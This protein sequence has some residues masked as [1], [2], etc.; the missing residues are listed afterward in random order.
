MT[1]DSKKHLKCSASA[2]GVGVPSGNPWSYNSI[3]FFVFDSAR[4]VETTQKVWVSEPV[5]CVPAAPTAVPI[6]WFKNYIDFQ[7]CAKD[8]ME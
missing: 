1:S 4:N 3:K 2:Y 5:V 7:A 6:M 8:D